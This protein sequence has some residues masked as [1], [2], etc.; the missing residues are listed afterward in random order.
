M[1]ISLQKLLSKMED[2]LNRAKS[3]QSESA[4]RERIQSIKTLCELVL[5]EPLQQ[6]SGTSARSHVVQ[7][8]A[9]QYIPAQ[10]AF[11]Q[12]QMPVS[13]A[14]PMVPQPKKLEMDDNSNGDSLF[15]F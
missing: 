4:Q 15:D 13:Q 10:P 9:Q 7:Q 14:S 11:P 1:N 8:P 6:G 12:Q 3:A 2:E 5:D